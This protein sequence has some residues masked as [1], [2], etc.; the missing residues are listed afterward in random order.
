MEAALE[1]TRVRCPL[2]VLLPSFE[3]FFCAKLQQLSTNVFRNKANICIC[4]GFST[5][6]F[7]V[8][9]SFSLSLSRC[10][11]YILFDDDF[12]CV[13]LD[14]CVC[15]CDAIE[16]WAT[17]QTNATCVCVCQTHDDACVSTIQ[18]YN[19]GRTAKLFVVHKIQRIA[20]KGI[21]LLAQNVLVISHNLYGHSC[22]NMRRPL[23]VRSPA[24]CLCALLQRPTFCR[25]VKLKWNCRRCSALHWA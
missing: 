4:A 20:T 22:R 19:R 2:V 21:S 5:S 9:F 7:D 23:A 24:V 3:R 8:I 18:Y 17:C 14:L 16:R 1:P 10:R 11:L 13:V 12:L 6:F 15:W 25:R